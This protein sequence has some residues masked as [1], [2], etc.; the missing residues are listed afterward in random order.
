MAVRVYVWHIFGKDHS[1]L[2]NVITRVL[3]RIRFNFFTI[4]VPCGIRLIATPP[5]FSLF[6]I[7]SNNTFGFIESGTFQLANFERFLKYYKNIY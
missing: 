2:N 1:S 6:H 5:S 3:K 4:R 7:S